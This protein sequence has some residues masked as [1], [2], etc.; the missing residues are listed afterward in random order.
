MSCSS[1]GEGISS[2]ERIRSKGEF[3]EIFRKAGRIDRNGLKIYFA[4]NGKEISRFA[5]VVGRKIGCAVKRNRIKRVI[6]EVYRRN[7]NIFKGGIDWVFIAKGEWGTVTYRE[8]EGILTG[9]VSDL[10][11]RKN[12]RR[13]GISQ[14]RE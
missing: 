7:K 9:A 2:E 11:R 3:K 12:F 14:K 10:E 5:V 13:K 6:R 4:P 8:I 1:A